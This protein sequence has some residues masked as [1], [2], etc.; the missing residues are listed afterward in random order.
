MDMYLVEQCKY[1]SVY[2]YNTIFSFFFGFPLMVQNNK[3]SFV[4]CVFFSLTSESANDCTNASKH[5]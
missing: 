2:C 3:E 5:G 4:L 1:Q